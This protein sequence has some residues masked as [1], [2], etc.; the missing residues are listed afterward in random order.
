MPFYDRACGVCE[1]QVIDTF[2]PV[3]VEASPCP[4]CG[5]ETSRVWISRTSQVIGDEM[6]HVQE[7]GLKQPRRFTSKSEWRRWMKENGL[8]NPV[9]HACLPGTDKSPHT[10]DWSKGSMDPYTLE[11]AKILVS[12]QHSVK[13]NDAPAPVKLNIRVVTGEGIGR[14]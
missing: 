14:Y 10:T 8:E 1:W 6:D 13:G 11:Q 3:N 12:R 2:E 7:N 9:R 4:A 5:S